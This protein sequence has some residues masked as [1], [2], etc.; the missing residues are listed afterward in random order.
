MQDVQP[1]IIQQYINQMWYLL[2]SVEL[3]LT[4]SWV[5]SGLNTLSISNGFVAPF[6]KTFRSASSSSSKEMT[7]SA[8]LPP[9]SSFITGRTR[10]YTRMLPFKSTNSLCSFFLNVISFLYLVTSSLFLSSIPSI[11]FVICGETESECSHEV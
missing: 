11:L 2:S 6:E 1:E 10:Q 8:C 9:P 3:F 4:C 7:F 5:D